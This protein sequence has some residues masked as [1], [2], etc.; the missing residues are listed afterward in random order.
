MPQTLCLLVSGH[1][2]D[3]MLP[4]MCDGIKSGRKK[5]YGLRNEAQAHHDYEDFIRE[6]GAPCHIHSDNDKAETSKAWTDIMR[7]YSIKGTT[8]E[9]YYPWQD[10]G[11]RAMQEI[12]AT[13]KR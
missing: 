5:A 8:S 4:K 10:T 3:T 9:P 13:Q 11:E 12:K 7:R 2:K 1:M 6:V